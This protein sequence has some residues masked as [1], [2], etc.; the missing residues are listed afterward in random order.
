MMTSDKTRIQMFA[1][2]SRSHA[3]RVTVHLNNRQKPGISCRS[4]DK[5]IVEKQ[6]LS[7]REYMTNAMI[8]KNRQN[9][10][11]KKKVDILTTS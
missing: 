5:E 1:D 8:N 3:H 6:Q 10:F 4:R 11:E 7:C 2:R 9:F